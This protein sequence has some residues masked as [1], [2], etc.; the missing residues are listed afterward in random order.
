MT[1]RVVL[2]VAAFATACA[3]TPEPPRAARHLV[4]VT[5]DTLRADRVGAYGSTTGATPHLDR[6]AGE[7]AF[8]P[9]A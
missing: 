1:R 3:R 7:G 8:A 6:I 5:I 9:D 4:I 2:L